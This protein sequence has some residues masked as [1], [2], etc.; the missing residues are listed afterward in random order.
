MTVPFEPTPDDSVEFWGA[1]PS[2]SA[3][4]AVS[5]ARFGQA[6]SKEPGFRV[7][8]VHLSRGFPAHL[9]NHSGISTRLKR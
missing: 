8:R 4:L 6:G 7:I 2:P 1:R 9:V 3:G 5:E